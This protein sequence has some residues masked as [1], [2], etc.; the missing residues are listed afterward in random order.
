TASGDGKS[1]I[2]IDFLTGGDESNTY[3]DLSD[4]EVTATVDVEGDKTKKVIR[5]A[6]KGEYATT[7]DTNEGG[8]VFSIG[9][10]RSDADKEDATETEGVLPDPFDISIQPTGQVSRRDPLT[11]EWEPSGTGDKMRIDV[12]GTCV[13]FVFDSD[14]ADDGE[15]TIDKLYFGSDPAKDD[16]D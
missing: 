14:E 8:A 6:S 7:F 12:D 1:R 5:P 4:D 16:Q 2:E 13:Y 15:Y 3:V 10:D 9:L 11:I